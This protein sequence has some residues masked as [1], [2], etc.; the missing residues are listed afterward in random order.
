MLTADRSRTARAEIPASHVDLLTGDTCGVITTMS[1]VGQPHSAVVWV[2][3]DGTDVLVNTTL[4]RA[5]GRSVAAN[6]RVSLVVVDPGDTS[7]FIAVRGQAELQTL[8]AIDHADSLARRY[9]G[10]ERFYG[11]V[12][13]LERARHETRVIVRIRPSHVTLDAI[14]R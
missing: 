11:C 5:T 1:S 3:Y 9:T 12:Y 4:E 6:G 8:G 14:H 2:D 10:H 7:R 13:P